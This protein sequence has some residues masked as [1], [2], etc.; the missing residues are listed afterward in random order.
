MKGGDPNP[1]VSPSGPSADTTSVLWTVPP[2]AIQRALGTNSIGI[3][4]GEVV[5]PVESFLCACDYGL[6]NWVPLKPK[7]PRNWSYLFIS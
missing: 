6:R 7:E 2:E 3:L 4:Q 1:D 5:A